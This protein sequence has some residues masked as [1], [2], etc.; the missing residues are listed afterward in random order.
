MSVPDIAEALDVAIDGIREMTA[1]LQRLR[2]TRRSYER[3]NGRARTFVEFAELDKS[4][5]ELRRAARR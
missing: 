4:L 2:E 3:V 5:R 1:Q